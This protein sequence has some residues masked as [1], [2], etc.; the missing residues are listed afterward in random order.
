MNAKQYALINFIRYWG[1][2]DGMLIYNVVLIMNIAFNASTFLFQR[3]DVRV[4]IRQMT[5]F[6]SL[7]NVGLGGNNVILK[8]CEIFVQN[9]LRF[10]TLCVLYFQRQSFF[11]LI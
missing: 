2:T 3:I 10:Q 5:L 6:A 11:T 1:H 7:E 9:M 8:K 4:W